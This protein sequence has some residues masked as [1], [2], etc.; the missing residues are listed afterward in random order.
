[1]NRRDLLRGATLAAAAHATGS[2]AQAAPSDAAPATPLSKIALEEHFMV[3]EFMEYFAET[4]QNISPELPK[5]AP[6][7]LMDFGERRL[8]AMDAGHI[9][10]VVLSLSG[11][12]VQYERDAAV[13]LKK[14]RFVNDFL[15]AE[16]QKRPTRYWGFAHLAMHNPAEAAAE[17]ER[18]VRQLGFQG[19]MINGQTNGEYLDLDK[20]SV[21]WERVADLQ[22]PIYLHPGNPVDHPAVYA[23]H[24]EL[25]GPVCSWAFETG[26]HALRLVFA[27]VFERYPKARLI[28]GHMGETLPFYLWRFDS[29]WLVCNRGTRTLPQPPSFYIRRNIA[30]TTSGVCDQASLRAALE[31]MGEENVMFSV[32]Y[33]FE[34]TDLAAQFIERAAISETQR[35]QVANGNAK[36]ILR[37]SRA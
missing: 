8:A 14:A 28:L 2:L 36:R 7:A 6:P 1:M 20:Y 19:A 37:L 12:G 29:R 9:D 5:L 34:K 11:P 16:I 24:S 3:P 18:C 30:I 4:Y 33:P 31:S 27:G 15:A 13:A 17:L 35:V 22:A 25:W 26:S 10:Y 23:D 32:D 21:F